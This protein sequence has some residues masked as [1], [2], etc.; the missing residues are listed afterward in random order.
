[1]NRLARRTAMITRQV[2]RQAARKKEKERRSDMWLNRRRETTILRSVKT[3]LRDARARRREDWELGAALT[4]MRDHMLRPSRERRGTGQ[5][6][7]K[8]VHHGAISPLRSQLMTERTKEAKEAMCAWA[9]GLTLLCLAQGDRVVVL[10]GSHKGKIGAITELDK[11]HATLQVE[12]LQVG[13]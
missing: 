12:G 8:P 9:G 11:E 3:S 2:E 5:I 13:H 10:E 1:M 4:P 6:P 7:V